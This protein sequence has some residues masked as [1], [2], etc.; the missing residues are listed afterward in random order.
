MSA[1]F[2]GV[3]VTFEKDVHEEDIGARLNAIRM[4]RGVLS[5]EPVEADPLAQVA[6]ERMRYSLWEA[7]HKALFP[8][9]YK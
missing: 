8:E 3:V 7:V 6:T 5:V 9:R 4:I 2:S 1:S